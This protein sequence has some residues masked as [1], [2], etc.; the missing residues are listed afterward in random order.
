MGGAY[1]S[2]IGGG[3]KTNSGNVVIDG[4]TVK[5]VGGDAGAGGWENRT[6]NYGYFR[7]S[8][9]LTGDNITAT[10]GANPSISNCSTPIGASGDSCLYYNDGKVKFGGATVKMIPKNN[11][12]VVRATDMTIMGNQRVVCSP[13]MMKISNPRRFVKPTRTAMAR[14]TQR[15]PQ[16]T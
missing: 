2:G 6:F 8:I 11:A 10:A 14:S 1:A 5:A 4:G 9:E 7:G 12:Q 15:T 3:Y 13:P 16:T